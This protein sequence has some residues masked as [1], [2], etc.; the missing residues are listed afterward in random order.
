LLSSPPFYREG[1]MR[2]ILSQGTIPTLHVTG[3]EDVIR[4]PGYRSDPADRIAVFD[5]LPSGPGAAPKVL[6]VFNGGTHSIFTDRTDTAGPELNRVVKA[7]TRELSTR[8][9]E[10]TLKDRSFQAVNQW[11]LSRSDLLA[12]QLSVAP[13]TVP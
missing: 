5:A 11:L 12:Q 7:A 4:I 2:S 3:T 9:L 13:P 6:A 10:A 8:F 1:D